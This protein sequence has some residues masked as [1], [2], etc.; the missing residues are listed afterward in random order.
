MFKR[1]RDTDQ[2]RQP[3]VTE[4]NDGYEF[5]RSRTLTGSAS[6]RVEAAGSS[7]HAQIKSDRL[8]EHELRTHRKRLGWRLLGTL[9]VLGGLYALIQQFVWHVPDI[10][11]TPRPT[12]A[13]IDTGKYQQAVDSYF[14]TRPLER[15][16]FALNS[17]SLT[18]HLRQTFP[19]V[20]S[21]DIRAGSFMSGTLSLQLRRPILA[22]SVG[23][24]TYFVDGEG[25]AFEMNHYAAP[26][27]TVKDKSGIDPGANLLAS[28]RTLR[29]IGRTVSLVE[30]AG[31]GIVGAVTIP[32]NK[33]REI[34]LQLKGRGYTI[35][36]QLDRDPASQAQDIVN[37]IRYFEQRNLKPRY[38]DVRVSSRAYYQ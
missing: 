28:D 1:K 37:A 9:V 38:V 15:F 21:A 18:Q 26:P 16:R 29:F 12:T 4:H 27:L 35:K 33:T 31:V 5:R 10:A 36:T 30:E 14:Q 13:A 32:P 22:W 11:A 25:A 6:S 24:T 19:E 20:A 23:S 7:G 17:Q 3:H 2:V 8:R 34:D